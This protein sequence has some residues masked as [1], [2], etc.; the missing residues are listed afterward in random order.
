MIAQKLAL[1]LNNNKAL[2]IIVSASLLLRLLWLNSL[3]GRDEGLHGY[4][5]WL[6]TQGKIPYVNAYD[7]KGP[8]LYFLYASVNSIFGSSIIYMRLLNDLLFIISIAMIYTLARDWYGKTAGVASAI[9]YGIFMNA[10]IYEGQLALSES[11]ALPLLVGSIYFWSS[12]LKLNNKKFLLFSGLFFSLSFLTRQSIG[13]ML[14]VLLIMLIFFS[15]KTEINLNKNQARDI[16]SNLSAFFLGIAIP[17][18]ITSLYFHLNGALLAFLN[19]AIV[20]PFEYFK[21]SYIPPNGESVSLFLTY[22]PLSLFFVIIVQGLP[23][24]V[25]GFLGASIAAIRRTIYDKVVLLWLVIFCFIISRP[26][27]FG[28]YYQQI[29]PPMSLL[30][31]T[32]IS[33]ILNGINIRRIKSIFKTKNFSVAE[34]ATIAVIALLLITS[35]PAAYMQSIQFPNYNIKWEFVEWRFADGQSLENQ[36]HLAEYLRMNTPRN[37][38]ILVHGSAAE[39]YWLSGFE[40]PAFPWSSPPAMISESEYQTLV[41]LV[42]NSSI[43]HVVLFAPNKKSLL[44]NIGDPIVNNTLR[45]YF[46]EKEIDNSWIFCKYDSE[47]RYVAIDLLDAFQNASLE[48]VKVD[49][50]IG[51]TTADFSYSE[52]L[53][54]AR[55]V[56]NI[57]GDTRYAIRQHPLPLSSEPPYVMISRIVYNITLPNKPILKYGIGLDQR[58][59]NMSDGV[60][61]RISLEID[62]QIPNVSSA[63]LNPKENLVDRCWV[64]YELNLTSYAN[65]QIKIIFE[66]MS[67]EKNDSNY[68]WAFWGT[69]VILNSY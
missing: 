49:G 67:G 13:L 46:F 43:D 17:L 36:T 55:F 30:A 56:L 26:P 58:I 5:G 52:G 44:Q 51:N 39:I 60:E 33:Q 45:K 31:G 34:A 11:I 6:W 42:Q 38:K 20:K 53:I 4:V 27:S 10:P 66:T 19:N 14:P 8:L 40:A 16:L 68:D 63:T 22:I 23:L 47:G 57:S 2:L 54:P 65:K 21:G 35:I 32:F 48:Y 9:F 15:K 18:M 50:S 64:D 69:P 62:Q 3:I 12:Y 1:K 29:I 7:N 41:H 28:H 25:S 61:F 37:S 59:W 24:W